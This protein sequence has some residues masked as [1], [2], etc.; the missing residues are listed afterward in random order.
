MKLIKTL[1]ARL[2][3]SFIAV[4]VLLAAVMFV[5]NYNA[6]KVVRK[7]VSQSTTNL[8][9]VHLNQIDSSLEKVQNYLL[10]LVSSENYNYDLI[11]LNLFEK[12]SFDYFLSKQHIFNSFQDEINSDSFAIVNTY[13]TY[14]E[15][16]NDLVVSQGEYVNSQKMGEMLNGFR[17]G[18]FESMNHKWKIVEQDQQFYLMRTEQ[19]Q[20]E[21]SVYVGTIITIES[22]INP[23]RSLDLGST[24]EAMLISGEAEPLTRTTWDRSSLQDILVKL[25]DA[26]EPYQI[27]SNPA[28]GKDY[29]MIG[30]PVKQAPLAL[31]VTIPD[32]EL[33]DKL[34]N[35]QRGL[36]LIPIGLVILLVLFSLLL[37]QLLLKPMNSL[38]RG[39]RRMS[40]GDFSIRLSGGPTQEFQF[41]NHTF[42]TMASQI[43]QLTNNVVEEMRKTQEVEFRHLQSQINP[44]FYLNSLNIIYSL[45][46][47]GR[48]ELIEQM[49]HHLSDFFR[50]ITRAN[51]DFIT[52]EEE[53]E[54]IRN[55]LEIQRLRFPRKL[56]F[57]ITV[58]EAFKNQNV[59]PLMIQPF[60]ENAVIHGM[61]TSK[62]VF[63]IAVDVRAYA[64][65]LNIVEV[66]ISDNGIGFSAEVL[67]RLQTGIAD[68]N[69]KSVGIMN[70]R[71]RIHHVYGASATILFQNRTVTEGMEERIG[72]A[73]VIIRIPYEPR[74]EETL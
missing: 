27:I 20:M 2:L 18:D 30:F 23:L 65:D 66:V 9:K 51:R 7:E 55:Y 45:A 69:S 29:I 46:K 41:L 25:T 71:N 49:A 11:S 42:N 26:K 56:T 21:P 50:F 14:I 44:H 48:T 47:L 1:R 12:N 57:E 24:G 67:E 58:L 62:H 70:V 5:Q 37:K 43:Q 10:R 73:E 28:N 64:Q 36:I 60:V 19:V 63:H 39:M 40:D 22:L 52:L 31:A 16:N 8:L 38:I 6:M 35:F 15:K 53:I 17:S 33:L 54:H 59:L 32:S 3:I 74:K 61:R 72:G 34:I 13:F 4:I 68:A